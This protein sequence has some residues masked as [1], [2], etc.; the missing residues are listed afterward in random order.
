MG[1]LLAGQRVRLDRGPDIA[2][3]GDVYVYRINYPAPI[4]RGLMIVNLSSATILVRWQ[5]GQP[6]SSALFNHTIGAFEAASLPTSS[7]DG[8]G[9]T[10][11]Y[12]YS[13]TQT[14]E[15]ILSLYD[16]EVNVFLKSNPATV[17]TASAVKLED[18]A[19][20]GRFVEVS[21]AGAMSVSFDGVAQPFTVSGPIDVSDRAARLLGIV[22]SIAAA[23]DVSDRVGRL[24]GVISGAVDVT[25]RVGRLLG[26]ITLASQYAEDVAHNSGD[27]GLQVMGVRR[28]APVQDAGAVGD[29]THPIYGEDGA[30]WVALFPNPK[31]GYT[32][33]IYA[34]Q[35][36]TVR[37]VKGSQGVLA[38]VMAY[39]PNATAAYVQV[40]DTAGAVTLGTTVPVDIIPVPPASNAG[41]S[42][43]EGKQFAAGIKLA[44]TTTALGSTAPAVGLDVAV[45]FH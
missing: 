10:D 40:F 18:G 27:P 16:T 8:A 5:G 13:T 3:I 11:V 32:P 24:L 19:V 34:A 23:V 36:T 12:V 25:D 37:T 41:W 35:T 26:L 39:N 15:F 31:A 20:A 29:Y 28:D 30:E 1:V 4:I 44:C 6:G 17:P 2:F 38:M 22:A 9:A 45:A 33:A 21:P 14:A 43:G 42:L 7:R